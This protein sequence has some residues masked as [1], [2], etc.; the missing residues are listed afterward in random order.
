M[1]SVFLQIE[2]CKLKRL[3]KSGGK[4]ERKVTSKKNPH[5]PKMLAALQILTLLE[6]G[7]ILYIQL[8][9]M[10]RRILVVE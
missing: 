5:F 6:S 2:M 7:S 8:E 10:T 1:A 9:E 4:L 3:K